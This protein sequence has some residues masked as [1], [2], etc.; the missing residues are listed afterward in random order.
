MYIIHTNVEVSQRHIAKS[1]KMA[2]SGYFKNGPKCFF[3]FFFFF[4][5][6]LGLDYFLF[7]LLSELYFPTWLFAFSKIWFKFSDQTSINY[8]YPHVAALL[9]LHTQLL[10][11]SAVALSCCTRSPK[12]LSQSQPPI[13]SH[14]TVES[15]DISTFWHTDRYPHSRTTINT[16]SFPEQSYIGMP[17]QPSYHCFLPWHSLVMLCAR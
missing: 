1:S 10:Q 16:P 3:F 5:C 15:P 6:F 7:Q 4:F 14:K 2:I 17:S 9:C 13:I 8:Q 12:T 11:R